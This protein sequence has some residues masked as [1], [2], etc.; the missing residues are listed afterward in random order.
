MLEHTIKVKVCQKTDFI[1]V[2]C[3][4]LLGKVKGRVLVHTCK[5]NRERYSSGRSTL[6]FTA[7]FDDDNMRYRERKL[8]I[9]KQLIFKKISKALISSK[10]KNIIIAAGT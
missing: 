4:Q 2:T 10:D 8:R 3:R 5:R 9:I 1:I 7:L 6:T